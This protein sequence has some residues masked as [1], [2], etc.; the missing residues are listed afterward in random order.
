MTAMPASD[1]I[2][3]IV[4]KL[5]LSNRLKELMKEHHF[6]PPK[7]KKA[8]EAVFKVD[9]KWFNPDA[10]MTKVSSINPIRH[11][12]S[13]QELPALIDAVFNTHE[14]GVIQ[15]RIEKAINIIGDETVAYYY[16][17][18]FKADTDEQLDSGIE[19]CDII[20]VELIDGQHSLRSITLLKDGLASFFDKLGYKD[21]AEFYDS[22]L[23]LPPRLR[24][25]HNMDYLTCRALYNVLDDEG[26]LS[27]DIEQCLQGVATVNTLALAEAYGIAANELL[28]PDMLEKKAV[29][30]GY[31][32]YIEGQQMNKDDFRWFSS[33]IEGKLQRDESIEWYRL[34]FNGHSLVKYKEAV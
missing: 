21:S 26:V 27:A 31:E 14:S 13:E 12:Q 25:K 19:Y 2:T 9:Y 22:Y 16:H 30:D 18:G 15:L 8:R 6:E 33:H 1:T 7:D 29:V 4:S 10:D 34:F 20:R 24:V 17:L 23:M 11:S 5:R 3:H 32:C 28:E